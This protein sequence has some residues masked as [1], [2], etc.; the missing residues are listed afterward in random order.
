MTTGWRALRTELLRGTAPYAALAFAA[1]GAAL[2]YNETEDWAG[3]WAPLAQYL[4]VM[5]IVLVPLA[6]AAGAWQAGRERRRRINELL[7]STPRPEWQRVIVAWGAVT[8]GMSA[9]L[10]AVWLSGAMLVAP[11]ATYLGRGWW[12]TL[13]IAFVGLAAGSAIGVA[14]GRVIPGR[15][16]G[17]V[18]GV[19]TYIVLGYTAYDTER[20]VSWLAPSMGYA[21][22]GGLYLPPSF[23][24]LQALWLGALTATVLVLV[25]ARRKLWALVPAGMAVAAALPIAN[26]PGYDRW[27]S[28]PVAREPVCVPGPP[29]VCVARVNEFLL[30][31]LAPRAQEA[32]ARWAGV[33]GGFVRTVD[34]SMRDER[35]GGPWPDQTMVIAVTQFATPTGGLSEREQYGGSFQNLFASAAASVI[36]QRCDPDSEFVWRATDVV[37]AWAGGDSGEDEAAEL[38][39]GNGNRVESPTSPDLER[40]L[41]MPEAEQKAWMG[42]FLA[43]S[44]N[45]DEAAFTELMAELG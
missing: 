25:G 15:V 6:V 10:L 41:A 30:D 1:S 45:C 8:V 19:L 20:G 28:D 17:P 40:L 23:H 22:D 27:I 29:E 26:G 36:A 4:R 35:D 2:L 18:A 13:G 44:R 38:V 37:W 34:S 31:E 24:F 12:W 43:A 5:L 14:I 7:G 16:V 11:V 42:R 33:P 21:G 32:L 39:D 9:G 3:R